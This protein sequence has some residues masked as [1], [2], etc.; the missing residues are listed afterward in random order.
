MI[1]VPWGMHSMWMTPSAFQNAHSINSP[2]DWHTLNSFGSQRS[3]VLPPYSS[4]FFFE[5]QDGAPTSHH[6]SLWIPGTH[7]LLCHCTSTCPL[8]I[9]EPSVACSP[10]PHKLYLPATHKEINEYKHYVLHNFTD[11]VL[12]TDWTEC[13]Y[14]CKLL[15]SK[16]AI[17]M[18]FSSVTISPL[19]R[20]ELTQWPHLPS[21][22]YTIRPVPF[23]T[24][25]FNICCILPQLFN[26]FTKNKIC[27]LES[28]E[29]EQSRW[30]G[31]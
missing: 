28:F 26:T 10:P 12:Y 1:I 24:R 7:L 31:D 16:T 23:F 14:Q 27:L 6:L 15:T 19:K 25:H 3:W 2:A 20:T 5:E 17:I 29:P 18:M 13:K 8:N 30:C 9:L 11:H 4:L 22:C 21:V